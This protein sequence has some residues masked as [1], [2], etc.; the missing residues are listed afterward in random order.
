[1]EGNKHGKETLDATTAVMAVVMEHL[2]AEK[3]MGNHTQTM[4]GAPYDKVEGSTVPESANQESEEVV[5][6]GPELSFAV[7]AQRD[8]E[9]VAQPGGE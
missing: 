5:Q 1:M 9:I 4:I 8:I 2:L 7:A 6:I 3:L